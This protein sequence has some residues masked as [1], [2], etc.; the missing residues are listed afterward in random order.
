MDRGASVAEIRD[1]FRR[2]AREVHPDR[3]PSET[4]ARRRQLGREFDLA[5][6][7]HDILVKFTSD[8]AR[9]TSPAGGTTTRSDAPPR[10]T[11]TTAPGGDQPRTATAPPTS[12]RARPPSHER[13]PSTLRGAARHDPLRRLR[14]GVGCR[15]LRPRI[16]NPPLDRLATR[17]RVVHGRRAGCADRRRQLRR[18]LRAVT[19]RRES[20]DPPSAAISA[21]TKRVASNPS[22]GEGCE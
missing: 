22:A 7:A 6:Q 16:T 18:R 3:H 21:R 9:G 10:T 17:R 1:A 19:G 20:G 11:P 8:A 12:A 13:V 14:E 2:R 4:E 5:R 15:G